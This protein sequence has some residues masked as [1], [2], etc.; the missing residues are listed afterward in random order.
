MIMQKNKKNLNKNKKKL[1][2]VSHTKGYYRFVKNYP[3]ETNENR[4]RN[5]ENIREGQ[6]DSRGRLIIYFA[7]IFTF[8][9]AFIAVSVSLQLSNKEPAANITK[10]TNEDSFQHS[11]YDAP[12]FENN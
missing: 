9:I 1:P 4:Y 11:D 6:I 12:T 8:I 3:S 7:I 5:N 10:Q 2:P